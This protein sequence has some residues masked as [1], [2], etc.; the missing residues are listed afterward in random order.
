MDGSFLE[1]IETSES[2][3][4]NDLDLLTVYW[5][6]DATFQATL[7]ANF[8][9]FADRKICRSSF[10]L[11]HFPFDADYRPD[12]TVEQT[13]YWI[14]LFTHNRNAVWKGMLRIELDTPNEDAKAAEFLNETLNP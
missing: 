12:I 5:G 13:R 11:D 2:R 1:D 3:P 6:Y 14:Q 7:V 9:E 8:P 10:S 4:P